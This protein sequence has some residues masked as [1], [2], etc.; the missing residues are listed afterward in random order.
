M[1]TTEKPTVATVNSGGRAEF[2]IPLALLRAALM[3]LRM[4]TPSREFD[5][6]GGLADKAGVTRQTVSRFLRGRP[7]VLGAARQIVRALE[8]D[9][10]EVARPIGGSDD[11]R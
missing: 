10:A 6:H 1:I 4:R 9:F 8:L 2:E 11:H 7:T 3:D 5:T